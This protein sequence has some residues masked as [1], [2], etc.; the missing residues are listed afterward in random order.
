MTIPI[1]VPISGCSCMHLNAILTHFCNLPLSDKT[2]SLFSTR[3]SILPSIWQS[4]AQSVSIVFSSS[5][6]STIKALL[7]QRI[8]SNNI[9]PKLQTS[10]LT[11]TAMFLNHLGATYPR[12]PRINR[13]NLQENK[14]SN[15]SQENTVKDRGA[16]K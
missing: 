11:V 4:E 8:I 2:S 3:A 15:R 14:Q 1:V 12:V 5:P 6:E 7:V 9:T 16:N 10:T 13:Y